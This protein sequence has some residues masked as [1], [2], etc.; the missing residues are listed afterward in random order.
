MILQ[1]KTYYFLNIAL[2]NISRCIVHSYEFI[3]RFILSYQL[4]KNGF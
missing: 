2:S 1:N 3:T 4:S